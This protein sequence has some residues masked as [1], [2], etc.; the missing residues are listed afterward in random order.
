MRVQV[1]E[2]G[3]PVLGPCAVIYAAWM[4]I[5]KFNLDVSLPCS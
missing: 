5:L 3:M 1:H 2:I 4:S